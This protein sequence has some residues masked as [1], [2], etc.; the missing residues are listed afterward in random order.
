MRLGFLLGP[1]EFVAR[2]R[3]MLGEWP[4]SAAAIAFGNAAYQDRRWIDGAVAALEQQAAQLDDLLARHG[5]K[6]RG[7]CPLFRLAEGE[8]GLALFDRLARRSILT[9]PF[10]EN[11]RWLRLG[12]PA[13]ADALARLDWALANG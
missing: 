4:V 2:M 9:R 8:D 7:E 11:R 1:R 5:L 13:N 3:G 6:V 10:Q 12:L